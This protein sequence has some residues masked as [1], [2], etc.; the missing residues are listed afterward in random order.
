MIRL[1][2]N[3]AAESKVF[4]DDVDQKYSRIFD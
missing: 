1:V 4:A 2:A 3:F